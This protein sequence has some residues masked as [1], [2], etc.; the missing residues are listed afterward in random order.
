MP[1]HLL[2]TSQTL[3]DFDTNRSMHLGKAQYAEM[4]SEFSENL[5]TKSQKNPV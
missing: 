5:F 2:R 3:T 1:D 4:I